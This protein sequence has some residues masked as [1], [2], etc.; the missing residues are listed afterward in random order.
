LIAGPV[1]AITVAGPDPKSSLFMGSSSTFGSTCSGVAELRMVRSDPGYSVVEGCSVASDPVLTLADYGFGGMEYP[2]GTLRVG[3]NQYDSD[4]GT[5]NLAVDFTG[6]RRSFINREFAA[7]PKAAD[8]LEFIQSA[9]LPA[10]EPGLMI[11]VGTALV[12]VALAGDKRK[13]H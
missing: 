8:N 10:P 12:A 4:P 9:M 5:D 6:G 3:E 11:L 13:H 7:K 2:W 1:H